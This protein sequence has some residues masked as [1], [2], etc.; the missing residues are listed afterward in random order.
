[1]K[2]RVPAL[3]ELTVWLGREVFAVEEFIVTAR[4]G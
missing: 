2:G 1:M 4:V 3:K